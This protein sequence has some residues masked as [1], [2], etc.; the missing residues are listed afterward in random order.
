MHPPRSLLAVASTL[1]ATLSL[2]PATA[3]RADAAPHT[4]EYGNTTPGWAPAWCGTYRGATGTGYLSVDDDLAK[5]G[6][7]AERPMRELA[8]AQCEF[9]KSPADTT[10]IRAVAAKYRAEV[11]AALGLEAGELDRLMAMHLNQQQTHKLEKEAC[12][13][14][15]KIDPDLEAKPYAAERALA[16]VAC[17]AGRTGEYDWFDTSAVGDVAAAVE[18]YEYL[19]GSLGNARDARS[20]WRLASYARCAAIGARLDRRAYLAELDAAK[21]QPFAHLWAKAQFARATAART[22]VDAYYAE[23]AGKDPVLAEVLESAPK[24][25]VEAF[26][27]MRRESATLVDQTAHMLANFDKRRVVARHGDCSAPYLEALA[28][29]LEAAAPATPDAARAVF[30]APLVGYLTAGLAMC[31]ANARRESFAAMFAEKVGTVPVGPLDAALWGSLQAIAAH[32][33]D[34]DGAADFRGASFASR[35]R[36]DYRARFGGRDG[37]VIAKV[38][39]AKDGVVEVR[40]KKE[41]WMEPV[42]KCR[43]TN[44]IDRVEFEGN[45]AKVIYRQSCVQTGERKVS[46]QLPP[47]PVDARFASALKPGRFAVMRLASDTTT[48]FPQEVWDSKARKVLVGYLG[49]GWK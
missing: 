7:F 25:A 37:G 34:I 47:T 26:A 45:R 12:A 29:K 27:A 35:P 11:Q 31:E 19:A 46:K 10:K 6:P 24:A 42:Y 21:L 23:L 44:R 3:G 20:P 41:S 28:A 30:D 32:R 49:F 48:G 1:A 9:R 15:A 5:E 17:R 38:A 14:F 33:E 39:A 8:Q 40:F 16:R 36:F 18:C 2:L 43:D 4:D 13:R 22:K